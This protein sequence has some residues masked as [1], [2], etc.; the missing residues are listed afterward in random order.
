MTPR[1]R[2]TVTPPGPP[3]HRIWWL[4]IG[5][6]TGTVVLLASLLALYL[7]LSTQNAPPPEGWQ[8]YFSGEFSQLREQLDHDRRE[9]HRE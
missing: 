4:F 1:P 6:G 7:A 9:Y 2:V 8:Q 3:N 5:G